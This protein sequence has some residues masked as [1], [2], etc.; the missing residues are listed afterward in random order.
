MRNF[1]NEK[2]G[3]TKS[4]TTSNWKRSTIGS[5]NTDRK[6]KRAKRRKRGR[7]R[8]HVKSSSR[9]HEDVPDCVEELAAEAA[10]LVEAKP[11]EARRR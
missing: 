11:E 6:R 1:R 3:S 10:V 2:G 9:T 4:A 5:K 8:R 7:I